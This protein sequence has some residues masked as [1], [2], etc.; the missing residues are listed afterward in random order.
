M[1]PTFV[2]PVGSPSKPER[3]DYGAS[4]MKVAGKETA[5]VWRESKLSVRRWSMLSSPTRGGPRPG[6]N[7][8]A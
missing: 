6:M 8:S 4:S 2:G 1:T 7:C 3:L 5:C